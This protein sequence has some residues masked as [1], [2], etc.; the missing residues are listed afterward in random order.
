MKKNTV[1]YVVVLGLAVLVWQ[2]MPASTPQAASSATAGMGHAAAPVARLT[3]DTARVRF[4]VAGMTCG[5]CATTARVVLDDV[6]GIY[7]P[8]VSYDSASATIWYD[9]ARVS[10]PAS[11]A[12]LKEMTGYEATVASGQSE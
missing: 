5:S 3:D 4:A 7:R 6:D 8:H 2:V 12:R 9:P 10:P 11:V 1:S